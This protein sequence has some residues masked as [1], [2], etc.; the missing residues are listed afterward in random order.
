ME[1]LVAA[2]RRGDLEAA[3][4]CYEPTAVIMA[5]PGAPLTGVEAVREFTKATMALDIAFGER[6]V[7]DQGSI[8]LHLSAWVLTAEG[9]HEPSR[10]C[11]TD[12]LRRQPDGRWLLA[13]DNAWGPSLIPVP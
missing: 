11:S 1:H 12:V 8:A 4:A 3:L 7:I 2:R 5:A 9:Q 13:I 6:V 10:G